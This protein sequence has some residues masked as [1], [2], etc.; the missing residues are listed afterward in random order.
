M[1]SWWHEGQLVDDVSESVS[2]SYIINRL[3]VATVVR[4]LKGTY[5]ECRAQSIPSAAPVTRKVAVEVFREF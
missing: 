3:F 1:V 4:S 2:N 5:F